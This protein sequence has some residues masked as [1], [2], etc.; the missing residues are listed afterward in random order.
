MV[1]LYKSIITCPTVIPLELLGGKG[2]VEELE[3]THN[4]DLVMVG[5]SLNCHDCGHDG[6]I[7]ETR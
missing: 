3:S 1:C 6:G 5:V 7:K 4:P 2:Q